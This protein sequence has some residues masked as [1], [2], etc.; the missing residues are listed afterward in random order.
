MG[1]FHN[2][3]CDRLNQYVCQRLYGATQ[4]IPAVTTQEPPGLSYCPMGYKAIDPKQEPTMGKYIARVVI[5]GDI[6]SKLLLSC[7][8]NKEFRRV[9]KLGSSVTFSA[10]V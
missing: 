7:W 1:G 4:P 10:I 8:L 9:P 6:L 5:L 3:H 2:E